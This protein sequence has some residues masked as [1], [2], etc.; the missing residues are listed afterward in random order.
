MNDDSMAIF[1]NTT[2][3][4]HRGP[5]EPKFACPNQKCSLY[6]TKYPCPHCGYE[7]GMLDRESAPAQSPQWEPLCDTVDGEVILRFKLC[8]WDDCG[9][10]VE[11]FLNREYAEQYFTISPVWCRQ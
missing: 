10:Q 8:R 9:K 6:I 5:S 4:G 11:W 2:K 3:G 7:L 1:G